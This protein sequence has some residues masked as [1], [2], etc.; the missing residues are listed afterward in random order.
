[1]RKHSGKT[2]KEGDK[3]VDRHEARLQNERK[4]SG[5]LSGKRDT[6]ASSNRKKKDV[7]VGASKKH[8]G[9][10]MEGENESGGATD[11]AVTNGK[12]EFKHS[13]RS[14]ASVESNS[15][16]EIPESNLKGQNES[17]V[18]NR[19]LHVS[20]MPEV[21]VKVF[22][23]NGDETTC[24]SFEHEN[25][26][27][28]R[29]TKDDTVDVENTDLPS[30]EQKQEKDADSSQEI[31][32]VRSLSQRSPRQS[33]SPSPVSQ[34]RTPVKEKSTNNSK[35]LGWK[36][37]KNTLIEVEVGKHFCLNQRDV[38]EALKDVHSLPLI[39]YP[40]QILQHKFST[41]PHH[42]NNLNSQYGWIGTPAAVRV[43]MS[44]SLLSMLFMLGYQVTCMCVTGCIT[45]QF[46]VVG[47]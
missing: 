38:E 30:N 32:D 19:V 4:Q 47:A 42:M 29:D 2:L 15:N 41:P 5:R 34:S 16:H 23:A 14:L 36:K 40:S 1:M 31:K 21:T 35:H 22:S 44:Q 3:T 25:K 13:A 46:M 43:Y 7:N 12:N 26:S 28:A 45:V 27:L 33:R 11:I 10:V 9:K 39:G 24:A 20:G 18:E 6:S 17:V 37:I 8:N